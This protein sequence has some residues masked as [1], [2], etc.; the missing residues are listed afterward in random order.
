MLI[1]LEFEWPVKPRI[2]KAPLTMETASGNVNFFLIF[3][4]WKL[5][6]AWPTCAG[7]VQTIMAGHISN[8]C[9][10]GAIHVFLSAVLLACYCAASFWRL[11]SSNLSLLKQYISMWPIT[12]SCLGNSIY[13]ARRRKNAVYILMRMKHSH[14][15]VCGMMNISY[16]HWWLVLISSI[17]PDMTCLI[18]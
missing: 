15:M 11:L 3:Q 10:L 1:S 14:S 5:L 17:H 18:P 8:A 7:L 9:C 12:Q 6:Q 13:Q 2:R 4:A 16:K